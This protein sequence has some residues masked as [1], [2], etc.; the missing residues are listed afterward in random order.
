VQT[1]LTDIEADFYEV[2]NSSVAMTEEE[3]TLGGSVQQYQP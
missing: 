1:T 3:D 2:G